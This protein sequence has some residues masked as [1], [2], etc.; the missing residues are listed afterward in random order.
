ML[1]RMISAISKWDGSKDIDRKNAYI[2]GDAVSDLRTTDNKL[3]VWKA[4]TK[5]DIDD[6][7]VALALNRDSVSKLSY[8]VLDE[9]DLDEMDIEISDKEA[10][11]AAGLDS[12]ILTKHRDLIDLDYWQLGFLAEYMTTLAQDESNQHFCSV[13]EIK[14]LLG[15]YKDECKI[16]PEQVKDKLKEKLNW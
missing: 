13:S 2:C 8:L 3:S 11:V 6:A 7:I 5:E 9:K 15:R 12:K 4:D 16:V 14:K 1:I 10:G